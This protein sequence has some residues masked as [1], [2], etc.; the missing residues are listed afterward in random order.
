MS[1]SVAASLASAL[2]ASRAYRHPFPHWLVESLLPAGLA[3]E[4]AGLA[5][6]CPD[7]IIFNGRRET[8]N[9]SRI[10]FNTAARARFAAVEALSQALQTPATVKAV[11]AACGADLRGTCLRIEY[12][13]DTDGFWL[14]PHTDISAKRLTM[15]IYLSCGAGSEGWGTDLYDSQRRWYATAPGHFNT[16]LIFIPGADSWHGVERRPITGV[17]RCLMIN[18]VGAE[19]RARDELAFPDQPV[20]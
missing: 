7:G 15:I 10:Y 13:Q 19:W 11:A 4:I 5:I 16:G 3:G 18:Y 14:E 6:P 9:S 17:R 1:F 8:N 20:R 2:A 12:C